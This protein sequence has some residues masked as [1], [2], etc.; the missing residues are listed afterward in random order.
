MYHTIGRVIVEGVE[1]TPKQMIAVEAIILNGVKSG[2][3][4]PKHVILRPM[5]SEPPTKN[6]PNE[7]QSPATGREALE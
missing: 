4:D 5:E 1:M 7:E 6:R 3:L 2:N